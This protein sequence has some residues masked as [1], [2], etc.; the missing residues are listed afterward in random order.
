M[1]LAVD[2]TSCCRVRV[3]LVPVSPIKKSSFWRHVELVK[4]FSLV[5]LGDVTPDLQKGANAK[6]SSQVFQEG[7]MHFQ[8]VTKYN[9][10]HSHLEDFQPHRRI[11]GVI[12]I[13]DCQ[14]W[15]DK[16]L[17]EGYQKFVDMLVQY[18]TAIATRCFAFDP[19]ENQP[20]DT[21]GLIMIPN[22]G[23]MSFY[24]STMIC[25]FASEILNQ[26]ANIAERIESLKALESPIPMGSFSK[27]YDMPNGRIHPQPSTSTPSGKSQGQQSNRASQPVP[28]SSIS[29]SFLKRASSAAG[30]GRQNISAS[31]PSPR[32]SLSRSTTFSNLVLGSESGKTVQRTPGRIKKL[33]ADFYLLAGRLPDAIQ[34]YNEA[35][36]MTKDHSDYLWLA[37]AKEGLACTM[38]LMAFLQADVGHIISRNGTATDL[39]TPQDTNRPPPISDKTGVENQKSVFSEITEMYEDVVQTYLKVNS[40]T[41][42]PIPSLVFAEACLKISRFLTLVFLNNGWSDAVLAKAV[43][44]DMTDLKNQRNDRFLTMS[45]LVKCK[46]SGIARYSIAKYVTKI[47][48]VDIDELSMMDQ[49]NIMTHMTSI[50]SVIGYHRKSAW[51]MYEMLNRMVPLLIQGRAAAASAVNGNKKHLDKN[52]DGILEVLKR[53]CEVYGIGGND[54]KKYR[55]IELMVGVRE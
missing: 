2:I 11:F 29:S 33:L 15:K 24:M 20:D 21:K 44:A 9:R 12:G 39:N 26:F 35:I 17:S 31:P 28:T 7:H 19:T 53:I 8:F 45:E 37:S 32:P 42:I 52:D 41:N 50:L 4:K 1:D 46:N 49:V 55:N 40:S 43:Y 36:E 27:K 38:L 47:W 25:D 23:N 22:V 6:F 54:M 34:F 3:L 18:P 16:D 51:F 14:E 10:E 5:R 13:M 30:T 48:L